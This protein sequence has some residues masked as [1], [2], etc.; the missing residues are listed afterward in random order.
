VIR[1]ELGGGGVYAHREGGGVYA[2]TMVIYIVYAYINIGRG[3]GSICTYN[4]H[5][6]SVCIY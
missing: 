5:L 6:Y 1:E 4:G 2:H 3:G